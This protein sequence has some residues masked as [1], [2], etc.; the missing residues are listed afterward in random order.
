[1]NFDPVLFDNSMYETANEAVLFC[2]EYL[3]QNGHAHVARDLENLNPVTGQAMAE[4]ARASLTQAQKNVRGPKA[5]EYV[6]I[7]LN[8]IDRAL[9]GERGPISAAA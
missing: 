4:F 5:A 7:A 9:A 2:K 3:A 8:T 1:M 6:R